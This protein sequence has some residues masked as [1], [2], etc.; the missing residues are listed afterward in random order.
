MLQERY[1][2]IYKILHCDENYERI[3]HISRGDGLT[4]EEEKLKMYLRMLENDEK[5]LKISDDE[6]IKNDA[7][8]KTSLVLKQLEK[9]GWK[10][11][12]LES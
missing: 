2:L 4:T 11:P 3:I 8:S 1:D 9:L 6:R 12:A 10:F 7:V 5:T